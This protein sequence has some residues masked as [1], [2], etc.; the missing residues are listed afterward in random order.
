MSY[1]QYHNHNG[2]GDQE[3]LR[4]LP[5]TLNLAD[6]YSTEP[7]A[8]D[9]V[10]EAFLAGTVGVLV[11]PGGSGKSML[12]L[13]IAQAIAVGNAPIVGANSECQQPTKV[14]MLA[15]EDPPIVVHHRLR[16]AGRLLSRDEQLLAV[17]NL[18]ILSFLGVEKN[19]FD[20]AFVKLVYAACDGARL[21]IIDT[22]RRFHDGEENDN[23]AMSRLVNAIELI[24]KNTGAAVLLLHHTGKP[25]KDTKGMQELTW[26]GASALG[27]NCRYV[28]YLRK[29]TVEEAKTLSIP[30]QEISRWVEFKVIKQNY[31]QMPPSVWLRRSEGGVLQAADPRGERT[32]GGTSLASDFNKSRWRQSK[33]A[34]VEHEQW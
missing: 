9:F 5:Q 23:G 10:L 27:D 7:P 11:S 4:T 8:F 12:A 30:E 2:D 16:S 31:A 32:Q 26:R 33:K 28:S 29:M 3:N 24:A 6:F 19:L 18:Q 34:E 21:V 1:D 22:L 20:M 17:K 14:V 25:S 13:Q 15:G